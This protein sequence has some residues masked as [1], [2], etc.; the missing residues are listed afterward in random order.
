[1]EMRE[2]IEI[3]KTVLLKKFAMQLLEKVKNLQ[4]Y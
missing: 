1:M 4:K 3:A 2:Q